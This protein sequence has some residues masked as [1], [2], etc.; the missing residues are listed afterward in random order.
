MYVYLSKKKPNHTSTFTKPNH[1]LLKKN[2]KTPPHS[3]NI[4]VIHIVTLIQSFYTNFS[5]NSLI[6][7]FDIYIKFWKLI[8]I[9]SYIFKTLNHQ[10]AS[11]QLKKE[12]FLLKVAI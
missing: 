3:T 12:T 4:G 11:T 1:T 8:L 5:V 7:K 9:K 6:Y 2:V 10:Y